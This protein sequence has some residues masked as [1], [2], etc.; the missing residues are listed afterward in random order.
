MMR[1]DRLNFLARRAGI[2][3]GIHVPRELSCD[4][5]LTTTTKKQLRVDHRLVVKGKARKKRKEE[6]NRWPWVSHRLEK[7]NKSMVS[8]SP[9]HLLLKSLPSPAPR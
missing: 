5:D 1:K 3:L 2:T 6:R 9:L 8:D 4:T 7:H